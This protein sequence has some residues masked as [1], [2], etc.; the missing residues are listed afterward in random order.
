[1]A[2]QRSILWKEELTK[3]RRFYSFLSELWCGLY[4]DSDS[5]SA[6]PIDRSQLRVQMWEAWDVLKNTPLLSSVAKWE[7]LQHDLL[8][9]LE[10]LDRYEVSDEK[11]QKVLLKKHVSV[12]VMLTAKTLTYL[13][14]SSAQGIG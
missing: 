11:A 14:R 6:G 5:S 8:R 1:M 3:L 7:D 4:P 9:V 2:T 13:E 10:L 12:R